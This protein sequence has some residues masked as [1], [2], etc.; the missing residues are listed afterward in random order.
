MNL[1]ELKTKSTQEIAT[2]AKKHGVANA[3]LRRHGLMV[4]I[5]G[6]ENGKDKPLLGE[7]VLEV[8]TDGFGFL[9]TADTQ[10]LPGTDDIYVSPSQIRRF[11]LHTGDS[12]LGVVR[13]PKDTERYFALL[14]VEKINGASADNHKGIPAFQENEV[15]HPTQGL[16]LGSS[17]QSD[18]QKDTKI[19]NVLEQISLLC[20]IGRGQRA[21]LLGP[22][23]S[24][25]SKV[26][27][28]IGK[29][30]ANCGDIDLIGLYVDARPEDAK[31]AV[32]HFSKGLFLTS[33]NDDPPSRHVQ[34]AEICI[35]KAKRTAQS[36]GHS[37]ILLDSLERLTRAFASML[38]NANNQYDPDALIA[39]QAR[40]KRLF[41][42]AR[43]LEEK[44]TLTIV[45]S[46][47]TDVTLTREWLGN[48]TAASNCEVWLRG[49]GSLDA[50]RS[51][52]R[53]PDLLLTEDELAKA[54]TL[55]NKLAR[56]EP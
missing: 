46:V 53:R 31:Q 50:A 26:L 27:W 48:W 36:G 40:V 44:G 17:S 5:L 43:A 38:P 24:G 9:R 56:P 29:A 1:S 8:L 39:P 12:V 22:P 11:G 6:A 49:D 34:L 2:I 28:G 47:T 54:D 51:H 10:Y 18:D 32:E 3:D 7:G 45:A 21:L 23:R 20:P 14:R 4:A 30:L 41:S 16:P 33:G 13:A 19:G 37:V 35:A 15:C 25:K 52:N 42:A 55:R